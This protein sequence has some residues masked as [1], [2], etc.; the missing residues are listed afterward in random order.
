MSEERKSWQNPEVILKDVGIEE[1]MTVA[2]MGCGPGFFTLPIA[3]VVG[4]KGLVHAVDSNPAALDMLRD[5][6]RSDG[7]RKAIK[8]VRADVAKTDISASSVD[9]AFFANVLHD[10][11]DKRTFLSEVR[12]ILMP[13]GVAVVVDWRKVNTPFGP[14]SEMRLSEDTVRALLQRNGFEDSGISLKAGPYHYGLV[15]RRK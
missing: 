15:F 13:E 5:R 8:I 1:G 7:M 9:M 4:E 3:S 2:D 11:E 10:I 6:I 14:P 12:R